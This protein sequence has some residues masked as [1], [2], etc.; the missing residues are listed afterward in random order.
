MIFWLKMM[1]F[2]YP[3]KIIG[4]DDIGE[5]FSVGSAYYN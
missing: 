2:K 3:K 1:V 5:I 4:Y